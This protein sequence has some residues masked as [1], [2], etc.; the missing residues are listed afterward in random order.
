MHVVA[1][2]TFFDFRLLQIEHCI[3]AH[4]LHPQVDLRNAV[5]ML[6]TTALVGLPRRHRRITFDEKV[7]IAA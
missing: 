2:P 1:S 3:Q 6:S 5:L 7:K 4:F